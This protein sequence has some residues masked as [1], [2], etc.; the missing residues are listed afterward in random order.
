M[1]PPHIAD[2]G[3]SAVSRVKTRALMAQSGDAEF[4][5]VLDPA[6][7]SQR[8]MLDS[9]DGLSR[10]IPRARLIKVNAG[11]PFLSEPEVRRARSLAIGRTGIAGEMLR[12]PED[13]GNHGGGADRN[14]QFHHDAQPV[15]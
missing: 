4:V 2:V 5:F 8:N 13:A 6:S 11:H 10:A 14:R 7:V 9:A 3:Y 12:Y 15:R 1:A